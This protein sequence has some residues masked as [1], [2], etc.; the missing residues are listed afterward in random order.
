V[1]DPPCAVFFFLFFRPLLSV[2]RTKR[3][4]VSQSTPS[5]RGWCVSRLLTSSH[6]QASSCYFWIPTM[7]LP[8]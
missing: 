8:V 3:G 4:E 7:L 5:S 6:F 1:L 2:S